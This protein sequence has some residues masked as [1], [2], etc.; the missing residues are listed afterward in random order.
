[1]ENSAADGSG[2]IVGRVIEMMLNEDIK[3]AVWCFCNA[4]QRIAWCKIMAGYRDIEIG[5]QIV[6]DLLCPSIEQALRY[7]KEAGL[8]D[9]SVF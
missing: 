6:I 3:Q 1:M 5:T 9:G 7:A 4:D 2:N 8:L